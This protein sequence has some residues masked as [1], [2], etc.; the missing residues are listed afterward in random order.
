MNFTFIYGLAELAELIFVKFKIQW[1]NVL[2][3]YFSFFVALAFVVLAFVTA[4]V[5]R[6]IR[7]KIY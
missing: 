1:K 6:R 4:T 7:K 5:L 2:I 3:I